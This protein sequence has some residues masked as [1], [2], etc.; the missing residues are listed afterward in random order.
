[1]TNGIKQ[2]SNKIHKKGFQANIIL[3][4]AEDE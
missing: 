2:L 3:S 1:M 4:F